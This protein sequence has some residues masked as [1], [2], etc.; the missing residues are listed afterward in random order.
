MML[1]NMQPSVCEGMLGCGGG[2]GG[3][4]RVLWEYDHHRP[5]TTETRAANQS[6]TFNE[7]LR[8]GSGLP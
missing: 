5:L 2:G 4:C 6:V 8:A 3:G 1:I 7:S